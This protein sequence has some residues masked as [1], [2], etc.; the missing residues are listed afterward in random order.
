MRGYIIISIGNSSEED[1]ICVTGFDDHIRKV[2][3]AK[4]V[5]EKFCDDL[6]RL[7]DADDPDNIYEFRLEEVEIIE[8]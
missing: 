5:A 6:Q 7:Y 2:F 3:L 8:S 1:Y 4:D